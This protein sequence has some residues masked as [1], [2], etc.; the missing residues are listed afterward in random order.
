M[1]SGGN[2]EV[3]VYRDAELV[4]SWSVNGRMLTRPRSLN[5]MLGAGEDPSAGFVG[6]VD[7]LRITPG[8]V[9]HMEF[10]TPRRKTT[11]LI[12]R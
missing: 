2:T 10:L 6:L 11:T 12:I 4:G 5:F 3:K 8:I 9:P 7:E 1:R